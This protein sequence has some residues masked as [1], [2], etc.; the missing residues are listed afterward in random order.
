MVSQTGRLHEINTQQKQNTAHP[1]T[2]DHGSHLLPVTTHVG[3]WWK[4]KVQRKMLAPW[5]KT[6]TN[7]VVY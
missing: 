2:L 1:P 5:K 4:G 3:S 6:M 7:L